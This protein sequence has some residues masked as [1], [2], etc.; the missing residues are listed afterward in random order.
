M[1]G[2]FFSILSRRMVTPHPLFFE[3]AG[4]LV[5]LSLAGMMSDGWIDRNCKKE[6]V[7]I[8]LVPELSRRRAVMGVAGCKINLRC[9]V[10][11]SGA[12]D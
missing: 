7:L 1:K 6:D 3:Y 12:L 4:G 11:M 9:L 10:R 5:F 2:F 8:G